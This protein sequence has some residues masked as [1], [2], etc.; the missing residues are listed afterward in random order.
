MTS[1]ERVS[2]TNSRV[3]RLNA[4][5]TRS[6]VRIQPV[7]RC[8]YCCLWKDVAKFTKEGD[9]V[10]PE[11]MG[12]SWIDH[13]VCK[14]CNDLANENADILI[15]QDFLVRFLRAMYEIPDRNNTIPKPPVIAVPV[16]GGVIKMTLTKTGPT[17]AAGLPG[18]A[19]E[20][21]ALDDPTDQGRLREIVNAALGRPDW[22]DTEESRGLA[23]RSQSLKTPQTAWSRFMAKIGLACGREAYG[24]DWLDSRQAQILSADLRGNHSPRFAQRWHYPP[25]EPAWPYEPPKHRLWIEP[26]ENTAILKIALFGQILGAVPINDLPADAYPSAWSL[27]PHGQTGQPRTHRSTFQALHLASVARRAE[28]AGGT[29]IVVAHPDHPFVYVPDGPN[30]PI[31]LGAELPRVESVDEALAFAQ[32]E[33]ER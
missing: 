16:S 22:D 15:S 5:R 6:A 27:D 26:F 4:S 31:D 17:F 9:H 8:T 19:I 12:G 7:R 28:A 29:A 20:K 24:E 14:A 10:I 18:S 2:D 3:E 13:S 30:G 33:S 21:L 32:R 1:V 11:S 23:R 25:V